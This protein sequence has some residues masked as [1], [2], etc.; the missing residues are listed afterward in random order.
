MQPVTLSLRGQRAKYH[1]LLIL[2]RSHHNVRPTT[3]TL[4]S[5]SKG[6]VYSSWG[7]KNFLLINSVSIMQVLF[8]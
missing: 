7:V 4:F 6:L 5:H 2:I 8:Q 3:V 1:Y